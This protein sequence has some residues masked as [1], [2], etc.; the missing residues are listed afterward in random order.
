MSKVTKLD[1]INRKQL[2]GEDAQK[3]VVSFLREEADKIERGEQPAG[4]CVVIYCNAES[5]T[6][7]YIGSRACNIPKFLERVGL[8]HVALHDLA[9]LDD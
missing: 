5:D 9:Q 6:T 8:M 2:A 3:L 1:V 4:M 7:Q